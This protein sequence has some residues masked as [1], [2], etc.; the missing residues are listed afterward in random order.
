[1]Y[2][3]DAIKNDTTPPMDVYK[4]VET[5]APAIIAAESARRGGELLEVPDFR[6]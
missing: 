2:F 1:M 3:I 6:A 4:A 5:A